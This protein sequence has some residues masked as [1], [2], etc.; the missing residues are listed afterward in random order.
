MLHE[1]AHQWFGDSVAPYAWS[2]VWLNEGHA[3]WYELTYAADRGYLEDYTGFGDLTVLARQLYALGDE[4]RDQFGPV[5]RP[6]SG[7]P[8]ALF[9]PNAYAGGALTLYALRQRIGAPAFDR[10]ER[11]WVRRYLGRSAS[12]EDFIRLATRVSGQADVDQL[13]RSWLYGATTPPMP[14]HPDWTVDPVGSDAAQAAARSVPV[15]RLGALR[16]R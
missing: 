3:T 12:T 4:F 7:D 2:D 8:R 16:H 13:L 9:S 5:A 1:L 14:G 10:L 15:G 6:R 11:T